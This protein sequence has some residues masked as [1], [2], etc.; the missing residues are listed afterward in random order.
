MIPGIKIR[1]DQKETLLTKQDSNYIKGFAAIG[2]LLAHLQDFMEYGTSEYSLFLRPFSFLGGMGVLLF[3]FLSGYGIFQGYAKKPTTMHYWK[4]RILHV[5]IPAFA[6]TLLIVIVIYALDGRTFS[7]VQFFFD[8]MTTQ[9]YIIA[10]LIMYLVFFLS[11]CIARGR[12]PLLMVV[13]VIGCLVVIAL[14]YSQGFPSRWYTGLFLFPAG[15]M[16]AWMSDGI[17]HMSKTKKWIGLTLFFLLF[18]ITGFGYAHF[19]G[20]DPGSC[21]KTLSGICLGFLAVYFVQLFEGGNRAIRW[22]GE[23]SL[24]IY[25]CHVGVLSVVSILANRTDLFEGHREVWVYPILATTLLF[26]AI[27][28]LIFGKLARRFS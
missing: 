15:M 14:F 5:M 7:G 24:Y 12:V 21:M 17:L 4:N 20:T 22:V 26:A 9:W 27:C 25:L 6:I 3:F 28:R 23:C 2:V 13:D 18:G 1:R 19:K 10:A 11:W 8:L 16:V